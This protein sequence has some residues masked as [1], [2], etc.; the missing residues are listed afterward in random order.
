MELRSPDPATNPYLL[1][2]LLLEAALEG[3]QAKTEPGSALAGAIDRNHPSPDLVRLPD[4]L[5]EAL[6]LA[7]ESEFL[8]GVL[9]W[10]TLSAYIKEKERVWQQ[11]QSD[12]KQVFQR[13][14]ETI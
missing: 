14:F 10:Q 9:P 12:P 5:G 13:H 7:M 3:I 1:F 8:K 4:N 6:T 11:F 2:A